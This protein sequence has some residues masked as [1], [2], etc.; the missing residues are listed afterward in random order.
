MHKV[1]LR[2]EAEAELLQAVAFYEERVP[3][4]GLDFAQVLENALGVIQAAPERWAERKFGL[5]RMFLERFPF[6]VHYRIESPTLV[7][8]YAIAHA[9]RKPGYWSKRA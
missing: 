9:S 1:E 7:V 6:I 2:E 5:R 4:L 3:G 8:V